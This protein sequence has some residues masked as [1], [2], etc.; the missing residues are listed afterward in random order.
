MTLFEPYTLG[1]VALTNRVVMSPMTRC[2]ATNNIPNDLLALYY[3]QRAS[4]GLIIT[5]GTSPSPEGLGYARI[6]G[7]FSD[8]QEL[9]WSRVTAAVHAEG[10]RIFLQMMHTGRIGHPANLPPGARVLAPSAIR[11]SG[12]IYT[13]SEGMQD[14]PVPEEMSAEDIARTIGEFA[15][16]AERAVRAGFDGIELHAANGYLLEQF[17]NPAANRR[18]DRY[19]ATA[20]G[21]MRFVLEVARAVCDRIGGRR[22]GIRVSP[23]GVFNNMG[24]FEGIDDFYAELSRILSETGLV[25]IHV[26]DHSGMGAPPVSAEV[27]KRIRENFRGTYILSGSYDRPRAEQ[28]LANGLGDLVAFGRPFLANPDLTEKLRQNLPWKEADP[29]TFYTP[30]PAGYTELGP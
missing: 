13:D 6:P 27:K 19:G 5:E 3:R 10:G 20:E 11:P 22:V 18:S 2:R 25:Y 28:D 14:H 8:A 26:V 23:Y 24:P 7:I 21:R 1:N 4:A 30:G 12:Q 15:D 9:G 17:L 16:G 29:A